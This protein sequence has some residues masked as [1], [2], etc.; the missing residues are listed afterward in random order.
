MRSDEW[1]RRHRGKHKEDSDGGSEGSSNGI[2]FRKPVDI[3]ESAREGGKFKANGAGERK[4]CQVVTK[5]WGMGE[6]TASV[7]L[8]DSESELYSES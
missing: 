7:F 5:G 4:K 6:G 1:R 3:V 2:M 8:T